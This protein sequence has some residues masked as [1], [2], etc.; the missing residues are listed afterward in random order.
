MHESQVLAHY[1]DDCQPRNLESLGGAGG[2]S[3]AVFWRL[4]T[5]TG[6]YCLRRWPKEHPSEEGLRFIHAVLEH[7]WRQGFRLIP[8]PR[9]TRNGYTYV[10]L[11]GFLWELAAW[12]PG[13]ADYRNHPSRQRLRSAMAALAGFHTVAASYPLSASSPGPSP[14]IGDRLS[15]LRR[16]MRSDLAALATHVTGR[17]W[18]EL[19]PTARA[20]L[21]RV[22][23]VAPRVLAVLSDA[24]E[25]ATPLQPCICDI[26]HGHVLYEG[27]PVSGL[28]DFGS[29]RI[30]SVAADIARLLG[31]MVLDDK[32]G[33][34]AG[35]EAY[36]AE[37]PLS[38]NELRLVTAFDQSTVL[39]SGLNWIDWI[40]R[41]QRTFF[42]R[43]AIVARVD[44]I[45]HRLRALG[46]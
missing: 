35:I 11:G 41:E 30:E 42:D 3:G 14:G 29:V 19:M 12:L 43:P 7:V 24:A 4:T 38:P 33:W 34:H 10:R 9:R 40:Y 31:S 13:E 5:C 6:R 21:A 23:D 32:E 45:L 39:M 27:D 25:Q 1:P 18:P 36:R 8:V 22:P 26:W 20:I 15:R 28:V 17:V 46:K 37:R 44:E 2:F 16:W